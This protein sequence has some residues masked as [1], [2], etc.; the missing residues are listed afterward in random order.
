MNDNKKFDKS[1]EALYNVAMNMADTCIGAKAIEA[2]FE[3]LEEEYQ[4]LV[5]AFA[6]FRKLSPTRVSEKT[7]YY[8][9]IELKNAW[10]NITNE[11]AD[12]LFVLL[13]I[14]H[15]TGEATAKELLHRSTTK[16]L[17]RMN[18]PEYIAKV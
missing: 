5:E 8:D 1:F 17:A 11:M 6:A 7:E 4:E 13:H 15:Q 12:V 3:K 16:M 2:R 10:E 14:A 9:P 18:D